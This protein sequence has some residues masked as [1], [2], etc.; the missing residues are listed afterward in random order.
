MLN[1]VRKKKRLKTVNPGWEPDREARMRQYEAM[2]CP[3]AS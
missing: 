1:I 3:I 2:W